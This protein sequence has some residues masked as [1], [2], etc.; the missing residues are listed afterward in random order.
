M[1]VISLQLFRKRGSSCRVRRPCATLLASATFHDAF[2]HRTSYTLNSSSAN[3]N[4]TTIWAKSSADY[5]KKFLLNFF[6]NREKKSASEMASISPHSS[7]FISPFS[8]EN[9][10]SKKSKG[11]EKS[12]EGSLNH[13]GS[14]GISASSTFGE[15]DILH[16]IDILTFALCEKRGEFESRSQRFRL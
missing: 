12:E 2:G 10:I 5:R 13:S 11:G 9:I 6:K 4:A 3:H 1:I 14:S 7:Q 15:F 8:V 16:L